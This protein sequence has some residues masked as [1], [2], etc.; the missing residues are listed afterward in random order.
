MQGILTSKLYKLDIEPIRPTGHIALHVGSFGIT[1][2][3]DPS[4]TLD[5]WHQR[6]GH[7]N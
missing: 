7:I 5:I 4:Q 6:F 3:K 1:T 2:K